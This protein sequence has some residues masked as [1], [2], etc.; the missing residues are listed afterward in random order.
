MQADA[1]PGASIE[2]VC[3]ER[4]HQVSA[5]VAA[6][7]DGGDLDGGAPSKVTLR[8]SIVS[9]SNPAA[10]A[11]PGPCHALRGLSAASIE[12]PSSAIVT[13]NVQDFAG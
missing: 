7:R 4:E 8:T 13:G 12:P 3:V 10:R 11:R 9:A 6:P 1:L 5:A 2:C